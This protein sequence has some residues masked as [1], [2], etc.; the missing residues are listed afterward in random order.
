VAEYV[1]PTTPSQLSPHA[2]YKRL[3]ECLKKHVDDLAGQAEIVAG[4][5]MDAAEAVELLERGVRLLDELA[6]CESRRLDLADEYEDDQ[7]GDEQ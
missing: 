5:A 1:N 2:H 3:L 6:D 7:E 4:Q